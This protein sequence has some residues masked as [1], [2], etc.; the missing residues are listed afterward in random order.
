MPVP[1][2]NDD[3]REKCI[4]ASC[5]SY[6]GDDPVSYCARGKSSKS[7]QRITCTCPG[8]PVWEEYGLTMTYFCADGRE[9]V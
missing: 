7:I 3:V 4:C 1:P 8:C 9:E 5:P 2:D 6:P